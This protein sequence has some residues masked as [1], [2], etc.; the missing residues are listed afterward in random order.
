ML[1][2]LQFKQESTLLNSP[3]YYSRSPLKTKNKSAHLQV[4]FTLRKTKWTLNKEVMLQ[5]DRQ[6]DCLKLLETSPLLYTPG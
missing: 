2:H 6:T 1:T 5:T 4:A 3:D